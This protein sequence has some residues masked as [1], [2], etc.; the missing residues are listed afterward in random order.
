MG[1]A[2]QILLT[3]NFHLHPLHNEALCKQSR[4]QQAVTCMY[5]HGYGWGA[6]CHLWGL[7]HFCIGQLLLNCCKPQTMKCQVSSSQ[8]PVQN[9]PYMDFNLLK[10]H[11]KLHLLITLK[12]LLWG[13]HSCNMSQGWIPVWCFITI[14]AIFSA[15]FCNITSKCTLAI[16]LIACR[17]YSCTS[18]DVHV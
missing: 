1:V 10:L 8:I 18:S 12:L 17:P 2:S 14:L 6:K 15:L 4:A 16:T 13:N 7:C 3:C 5:V 9:I 11:T